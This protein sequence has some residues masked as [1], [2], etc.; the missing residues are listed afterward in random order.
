MRRATFWFIFA[1]VLLVTAMV[2]VRRE[3]GGAAEASQ[4]LTEEAGGA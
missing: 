3:L 1:T 2:V 4:P